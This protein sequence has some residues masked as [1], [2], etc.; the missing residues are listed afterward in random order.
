MER[1]RGAWTPQL[2]AVLPEPLSQPALG[3]L[4]GPNPVHAGAALHLA[5]SQAP[6]DA[7]R[8][9][10]FDVTGR[11]VASTNLRP[12]AGIVSIPGTVAGSTA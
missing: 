11:R 6:A 12:G 1:E 9:E 10:V 7:S 3:L 4:V 5:W 8:L 2:T